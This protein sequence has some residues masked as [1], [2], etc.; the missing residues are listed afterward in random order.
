MLTFNTRHVVL[1]LTLSLSTAALTAAAGLE[2]NALFSDH[3]VLEQKV[4]V[5][6]WGT[7]DA[8]EKVTVRFA[9]QEV[10]AEPKDGRWR[11]ELKPLAAGGPHLMTIS[12]GS[13]TREIHDVL[14][15][16]VWICGG[17]SNMQWGLKQSEGGSEAIANS[18]NNQLRLIHH[19]S[20]RLGKA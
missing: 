20:Q 18:A 19:S 10:S 2:P 6:V 4:K 12:Q 11:V 16:E 1:A 8:A 3:A 13:T 5:P 7:T 15:G 9:G 17:Q 14:V